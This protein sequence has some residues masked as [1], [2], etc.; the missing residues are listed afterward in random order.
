MTNATARRRHAEIAGAGLSGLTTATRLAQ[1]GWTVRVHE[2]ADE[3]T[4]F[5]A[6]FWLWENG[7]RSLEI[8]GAADD[9]AQGPAMRAWQICDPDGTVLF[10]RPASATDRLILARRADIYEALLGKAREA[11]VE[12]LTN[13]VAVEADPAGELVLSDGQR[14]RADLVV[15][16]DGNRSRVRDSVHL[17]KSLDFGDSAGIRLLIP[18]LEGPPEDLA[19][20]YWSGQWRLLYNR[21]SETE[22]YVFLSTPVEDKR[23]RRI[24]IDHDLWIE[25][26]PALREIISRFGDG[27]RWDRLLTVRCRHWSE[28]A[29]AVVGDAAHAMRPNLGQAGNIAFVNAIGLAEEVSAADDVPAALRAWEER[30]KPITDHVQRWSYWYGEVLQHWPQSMLPARSRMLKTLGR[31][32][33]FAGGIDR[34]AHSIPPVRHPLMVSGAV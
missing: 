9:L 15:A 16:A 30:M 17:I 21:C 19:S 14:L 34:G 13:S 1:L 3:L 4:M 11:G 22:D 10:S 24:P 33:W 25:H 29:V 18:R 28:G 26:F 8:A 20:E 5:G 2:R 23:S 31:Q 6:G 27:G 7:L 32:P 12:I